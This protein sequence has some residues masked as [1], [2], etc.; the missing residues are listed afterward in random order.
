M[1]Q[2]F[3]GRNFGGMLPIGILADKTLIL[4]DWLSSTT[5]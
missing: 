4:A 2:N 3:G 5:K 1:A